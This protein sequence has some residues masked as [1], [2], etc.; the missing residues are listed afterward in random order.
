MKRYLEVINPSVRQQ[1]FVDSL[2]Y[3][4]E[5]ATRKVS[6][7]WFLQWAKEMFGYFPFKGVEEKEAIAGENFYGRRIPVFYYPIDANGCVIL[8][9]KVSPSFCALRDTS[10]IE[11]K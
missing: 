8:D 1:L 11:L 9:D 7:L 3:C 4:C 10:K 2:I 5:G 6:F